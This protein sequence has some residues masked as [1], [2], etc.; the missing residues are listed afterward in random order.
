M[1]AD[2]LCHPL[3]LQRQELTQ[4]EFDQMN[5]QW[6]EVSREWASIEGA[7]S[8]PPVPSMPKLPTASPFATLTR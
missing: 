1:N 2:R 5:G 4:D 8:W 6:L 7:S 3:T